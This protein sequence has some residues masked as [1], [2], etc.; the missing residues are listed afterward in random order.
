MGRFLRGLPSFF[1]SIRFRLTVWYSTLLSLVAGLLLAVTYVVV[2]RSTDPHPITQSYQA[3]LYDRLDNGQKR[4]I[5]TMEVAEVEEIESAVNYRTLETLRTFSFGALGGLFLLSLGIGWVLAGR[6]LR[7]V[8]AIARTAEEIQA[9]DL[10]R[11][12]QLG[13][14]R[15][16]LRYLAD[17][18]DSML[19]RLDTAFRTQRQ[20]IDDVSH[21]LRSPLTIMR[22]NLDVALTSPDATEED[23]RRAVAV[24]DRATARMSNLVED[25]LASARRSTP[26]LADTDVDLAAVAREAMEDYSS[27]ASERGLR[28]RDRL[29]PSL[30]LIGD[31]EALRRAIGNLL[32]NAV[33][34]APSNSDIAVS[35]GHLDG[36]LWL[37]VADRGPGIAEPDQARVFDRFWRGSGASERDRRTGLGLAIV[38]QVVESHGGQVALHSAPG[39]GSTFVLWFPSRGAG[40]DLAPRP[41]TNPLLI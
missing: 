14:A 15:D 12:I 38:R 34:L 23:R 20:L 30:A 25:L 29:S 5:G 13:G 27:L 1:Q 37:G 33:R 28:L 35:S 3:S 21:E 2:E 22:A 11:R 9:T 17:T 39:E 40:S 16:E 41:A 6:A 24:M 7:P 10:S 18:V 32:S 31:P 8:R 26:A 4:Y 36:W 19:D